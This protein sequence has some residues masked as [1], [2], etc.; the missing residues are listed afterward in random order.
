MKVVGTYYACCKKNILNVYLFLI[1]I[2]CSADLHAETQISQAYHS[3]SVAQNDCGG[4]GWFWW[5]CVLCS[6]FLLFLSNSVSHYVNK[7]QEAVSLCRG[8]AV[9]GVN[10]PV[11][12]NLSKHLAAIWQNRFPS[13]ALNLVSTDGKVWERGSIW[14]PQCLT[15]FAVCDAHLMAQEHSKSI[16]QVSKCFGVVF[17]LDAFPFFCIHLISSNLRRISETNKWQSALTEAIRG[18]C[19]W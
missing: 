8:A 2:F 10:T 5:H 11:T 18:L 3:A 1:L 19:R 17:Q 12:N 15:D 14:E 9:R 4:T 13:L 7:E 6:H 16:A